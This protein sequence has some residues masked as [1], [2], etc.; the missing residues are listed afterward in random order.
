MT[1]EFKQIGI[2]KTPYTDWAP[3]HP[4]ERGEGEFVVELDPEYAEGLQDL[5]S[6]AYV[7]VLFHLD[8]SVSKDTYLARP[9]WAKGREVGV[10]ASRSPRRPNLIGLSVVRVIRVEGNRLFTSPLDVLDGTPLIDLKP[11]I[12]ATDAKD[13]ANNG[14]IDTLGDAEHML[15]HLRGVTHEHGDEGH[16]HGHHHHHHHHDHEHEH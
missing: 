2:I 10:F 3:H 12:K 1:I 16:E 15:Q 9:P 5:D 8:R 13:D 6:F 11:Y 14:W 7:H 4:L